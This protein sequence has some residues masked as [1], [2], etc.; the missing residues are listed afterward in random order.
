MAARTATLTTFSDSEVSQL[1]LPKMVVKKLSTAA[2]ACY[3]AILQNCYSREKPKGFFPTS[4]EHDAAIK[5]V[6][7]AEYNEG[8]IAL[9]QL[10]GYEFNS[11]TVVC[12]DH[13]LPRKH[14]NFQA[15]QLPNLAITAGQLADP[16][17]LLYAIDFK[18]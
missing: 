18:T 17:A 6:I 4:Q 3:G 9:P 13:F 15:R 7:L 14:H 12:V 1:D 5:T 16:F 10:V 11:E 8:Y 2:C